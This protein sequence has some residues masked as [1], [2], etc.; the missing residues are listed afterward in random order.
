[1]YLKSVDG[2]VIYQGNEKSVKNELEKSV[3]EGIDLR[4]I[5]L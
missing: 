1:M 4:N 3:S 2:N 5:N